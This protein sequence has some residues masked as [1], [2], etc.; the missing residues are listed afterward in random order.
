MGLGPRGD[1]RAGPPRRAGPMMTA[2][3]FGSLI[4]GG[5]RRAPPSAAAGPPR[6]WRRPTALRGD[7][8]GDARACA[9]GGTRSRRCLPH[10][11]AKPP[12]L[13]SAAR[14]ACVVSFLAMAGELSGEAS[15]L[16]CRLGLHERV[17]PVFAREG[18]DEDSLLFVSVEDLVG[19]GVAAEDARRI[20]S[21]VAVPDE[22]PVE[23]VPDAEP[24]EAVAVLAMAQPRG[25]GNVLT[26]K[27]MTEEQKHALGK[28]GAGLL[29]TS[30]WAHLP[31]SVQTACRDDAF[32]RAV[33]TEL[34]LKKPPASSLLETAIKLYRA[35][36]TLEP[37]KN[38]RAPPKRRGPPSSNPSPPPK[39][40]ATSAPLAEQNVNT[41]ESAIVAVAPQTALVAVAQHALRALNGETQT[42]KTGKQKVKVKTAGGDWVEYESRS[43][44]LR[45]VSGLKDQVLRS[46]L[47]GNASAS[48]KFEACL[49]S[50]KRPI[51]KPTAYC[52]AARALG[53]RQGL[54]HATDLDAAVSELVDR[55]VLPDSVKVRP[56]SWEALLKYVVSSS[57]HDQSVLVAQTRRAEDERVLKS[58]EAA[59][60]VG[61]DV[62]RVKRRDEAEAS[63]LATEAAHVDLEQLGYFD[64]DG[65]RDDEDLLVDKE[66]VRVSFVPDYVF[67]D[68]PAMV[69]YKGG[70]AELKAA[71]W[72]IR[73]GLGPG[74]LL[75][76]KDGVVEATLRRPTSAHVSVL[77][78]ELASGKTGR[79]HGGIGGP[80]F[81]TLTAR[82]EPWEYLQQR[83]HDPW[84]QLSRVGFHEAPIYR[85][86]ATTCDGEVIEGAG[87]TVLGLFLTDDGPDLIGE[88]DNEL[89][90]LSEML[91][92]ATRES[93]QLSNRVNAGFRRDGSGTSRNPSI[94]LC[95]PP[96]YRGPTKLALRKLQFAKTHGFPI[97]H[98]V[99]R[100][101]I[102]NCVT[103]ELVAY[104]EIWPDRPRFHVDSAV[105]LLLSALQMK[106]IT[107]KEGANLKGS[108]QHFTRAELA[109]MEECGGD[110]SVI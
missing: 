71:G 106:S 62:L 22:E 13:V 21:A 44:A 108:K 31:R 67:R 23:A 77:S 88:F 86:A 33:Q 68:G 46:L 54:E 63:A 79:K 110:D 5:W 6:L 85:T 78:M 103:F 66:N 37:P 25:K 29:E 76:E 105:A 34:G 49:V 48:D 19:V 3:V 18:I 28:T 11:S 38:I 99:M 95:R 75:I 36:P 74:D 47:G 9:A 84:L 35:Q 100:R 80:Y 58:R 52:A 93:P 42:T 24:V 87:T 17:G 102:A 55:A 101:C 73:V 70:P 104:S 8:C 59:C 53:F 20:V 92:A 64:E 51:S 7:V 94:E 97:I 40:A 82:Q 83:P 56:K 32:V 15:A 72:K 90:R 96:R 81:A 14:P 61:L 91:R 41:G 98:E 2:I 43:E 57:S 45:R 26:N 10:R 69:S 4:F 65:V 60:M 30:S 39:R 12:G 16:L 107:M 1:G 50:N 27:D 109:P 89:F